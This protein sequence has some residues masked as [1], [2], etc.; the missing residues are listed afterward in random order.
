MAPSAAASDRLIDL[1]AGVDKV[2]ISRAAFGI[3]AGVTSG[4]VANAA[5][6]ASGPGGGV[7]LHDNAV[8]GAGGLY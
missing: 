8:G 2:M 1:E 5:P 7:L 6:A 4:L 3:A